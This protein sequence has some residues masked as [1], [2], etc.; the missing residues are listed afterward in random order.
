MIIDYMPLFVWMSNN[1]TFTTTQDVT[2]IGYI[3]YPVRRGVHGPGVDS[4]IV[5]DVEHVVQLI[6]AA[7]QLVL[8]LN[9]CS[10][11]LINVIN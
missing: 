2:D 11:K 7:V 5:V 9:S 8:Q 10:L 6:V 3:L 1:V 4:V